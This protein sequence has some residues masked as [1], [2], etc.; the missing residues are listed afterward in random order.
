[1][2]SFAPDAKRAL[3]RKDRP[4]GRKLGSMKILRFI[5]LLLGFQSLVIDTYFS[6]MTMYHKRGLMEGTVLVHFGIIEGFRKNDLV[7]LRLQGRKI[8][9]LGIR[10]FR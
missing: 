10:A 5:I 4:G 7:L 8:A 9:A 6:D 3:W 1:M 2:R